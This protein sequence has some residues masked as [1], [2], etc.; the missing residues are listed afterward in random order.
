VASGDETSIDGVIDKSKLNLCNEMT[1]PFMP[2]TSFYPCS[3]NIFLQLE[4]DLD[5]QP[6]QARR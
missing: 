6:Q 3:V 4:T 5:T 1:F 2:F